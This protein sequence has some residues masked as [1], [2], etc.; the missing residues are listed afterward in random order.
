M[1]QALR[2]RG[3]AVTVLAAF[4]LAQPAAL[5]T[6]L[7]LVER[8]HAAG[9]PM[10]ETVRGTSTLTPGSCHTTAA[11][12]IQRDRYSVLSPM[13]PSRGPAIAAELANQIEPTPT[14]SATPRQL[15]HPIESP[16]PRRP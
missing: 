5:C 6:A 3:F 9:H 1:F 7:C 13:A 2:S 10:P 4:L 16:P 11:G 8:H 12:A 15:F 14:P